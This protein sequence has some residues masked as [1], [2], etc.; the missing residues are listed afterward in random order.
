M[1]RISFSYFPSLYFI[2]QVFTLTAVLLIIAGCATRIAPVDD[3]M[4][5][6]HLE[7]LHVGET[8]QQEIM[9]RLGIPS[10]TY[11]NGLVMTYWMGED[12]GGRLF[13]PT[14]GSKMRSSKSYQLVLVFRS[15]RVLERYNLIRRG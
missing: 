10:S 5:I 7:F 12:S 13:V 11:E 8:T 9:N 15:D 14:V 4:A 2:K 1:K 6:Q 3:K